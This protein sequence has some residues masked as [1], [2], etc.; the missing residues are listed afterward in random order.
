MSELNFPT[1]KI[2]KDKDYNFISFIDVETTGFDPWRNEIIQLA[3]IITDKEAKN[4]LDVFNQYCRPLCPTQWTNGAEKVH[5]ITLN[6]ALNFQ[7]PFDMAVNFLNFLK[8]YKGDSV[9]HEPKI[10]FVCHSKGRFDYRFLETF[11][12][13]LELQY[14]FWK[15]F[16]SKLYE[17]TIDCVKDS[18]VKL[19]N[20]KLSTI[21]KYIKFDL[22]HHEALSDTR[23]C[24]EIYKYFKRE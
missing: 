12:R 8:P 10:N 22:N 3:C 6:E 18:F 11:F 7:H 4:E 15:V 17:S 19:P 5:R 13:K 24:K 14:S 9:Y 23:A 21:A 16:D 1:D 20:E 2:K